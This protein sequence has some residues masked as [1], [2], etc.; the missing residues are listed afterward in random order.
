MGNKANDI[1]RAAGGLVWLETPEGHKVAVVHRPKYDDWCL[2]KGKLEAGESFKEAAVREV[3]EETQCSA[4]LAD[5]AGESSYEH[6][7]VPKV[8]RYWNMTA[9]AK[10]AFVPNKEVDAL[11]WLSP[12]EALVKLDHR[13]ER[14]IL[15]AAVAKRG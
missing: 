6:H 9:G 1:I 4:T 10:P 2:P 5:F 13:E 11:E 8:V 14:K 7:G 15:A 12:L 3:R